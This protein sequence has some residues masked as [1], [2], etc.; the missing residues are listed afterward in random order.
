VHG[1]IGFSSRGSRFSDRFESFKLRT[2]VTDRESERF[3]LGVTNILTS[4]QN[5][6]LLQAYANVK[7]CDV[8]KCATATL[9]SSQNLPSLYDV[10]QIRSLICYKC[11]SICICT[12]CTYR[13][14]SNGNAEKLVG[15]C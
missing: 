10:Q 2:C 6:L 9:G 1:G 8:H 5:F 4:C 14:I 7:N 12:E 13:V 11:I 3:S 15:L